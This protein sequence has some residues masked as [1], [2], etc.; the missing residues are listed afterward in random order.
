VREELD[1]SAF[2]ARYRPGRGQP[3]YHPAMMVALL[4]Y[5]YSRGVY[6]SRR[7]ERA[8]VERVDFMA[9]TGM[10]KPDHDTICTFRNEHAAALRELFV[11]VL[12]LCRDAGLA[13]LGHVALDG[14]KVKA[15]ASKH[16]AM[17]HKRMQEREPVL[18]AEVEEWLQ[19]AQAAYQRESE[20][21]SDDDDP[22]AH[23]REKI[24]QLARL[25][26]SKGRLEADAQETAKCL[27]AGWVHRV[28]ALA[29]LGCIAV[30][31][32]HIAHRFIFLREKGLWTGPNTMLPRGKD[33]ADF[34][35]NVRWFLFLGKRPR[36]DRWTYWEKADFWAVFWGIV[37]IGG[38][39][40]ILWFPET[41]TLFMPG[42]MINVASIVHGHEAL[43]AVAFILTF[44]IFHAN[45]RPD[46]FPIDPLFL[47]GRYTEEELKHERPLEYERAVES[48]TLDKLQGRAPVQATIRVAYIL[49]MIVMISGIV[50][51]VL[52]FSAPN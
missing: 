36:Y 37:I 3:P 1:L 7:I 6:S 4:L 42:W 33:F 21:G 52:M 23:V 39:G 28:S 20:Q 45:L 8:C 38:T 17:S 41:A 24:E 9:V 40:L 29:M 27:A 14:S 22:P 48:G 11:Q 10:A 5:G 15:S 16:K 49:G 34:C 26:A 50:L 51:V 43:L 31:L 18:A 46:K 44:H 47:T 25:R 32:I 30:Y 35:G 13:K 19:A 12:Q 2:Y